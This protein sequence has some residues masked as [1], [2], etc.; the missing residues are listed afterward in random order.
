MLDPDRC[1]YL[2]VKVRFPVYDGD[3]WNEHGR[4]E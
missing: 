2:S 1:A 4:F 3:S